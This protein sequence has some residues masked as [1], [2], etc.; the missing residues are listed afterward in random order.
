MTDPFMDAVEF[1]LTDVVSRAYPENAVPDKPEY[2]YL[3]WSVADDRPAAYTLDAVHG[4]RFRR[5][6][7]Q[8]FGE[9]LAGARDY[10]SRAAGVFLDQVLDVEGYD[11][12]PMVGDAPGALLGSVN[13]DPDDG[14]V[15]SI[16]SSLPFAAIKEQP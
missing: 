13:R 3:V 2:P 1:A 10:D 5:V 7:W 14:G 12:G 9:T 6:T 8:S 4:M 11:C 15:I 16:T